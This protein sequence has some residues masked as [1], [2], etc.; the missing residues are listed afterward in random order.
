MVD[1]IISRCAS[2]NSFSNG[3]TMGGDCH[4]Y[5]NHGDFY[6]LPQIDTINESSYTVSFN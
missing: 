5:F 2:I 6:L 1:A 3:I 4:D